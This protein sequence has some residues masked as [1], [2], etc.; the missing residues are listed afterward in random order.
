MSQS[1]DV[2]AVARIYLEQHVWLVGWLR[3][4]VGC[5]HAAA[6]FAHDTFARLIGSGAAT[7]LSEP[8]AWL[9]TTATRLLVDDS[10][11]RRIEQ[12]FLASWSA[13]HG[14][15]VHP[16]TELVAQACQS[17]ALLDAWLAGTSRKARAAFLMVRVEGLTSAEAGI[18]LG[19]SPGRVRQYVAE[20]LTHCY[21]VVFDPPSP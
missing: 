21:T 5:P 8:R 18:R 3:R 16:S 1:I 20:V 10:R 6:D 7:A 2:D 4:R 13:L 17:I 11:R 12:V 19:I 9:T 15:D 14:S